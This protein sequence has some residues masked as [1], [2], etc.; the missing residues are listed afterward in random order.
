MVER[1]EMD[2]LMPVVYDELQRIAGGVLGQGGPSSVVATDLVH[3][4]Y[5][6]LAQSDAARWG[7]RSHFLSLAA[8]CMRQVIIDYRRQRGAAKR[9]GDWQRVTLSGVS[10]FRPGAELDSFVIAE[11][12]EQ[13]MELDPRQARVVELR[14]YAGLTNAEIAEVL[15]VSVPTVER[16]W[17]HARAWLS[18]ELEGGA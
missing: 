2:D 14:F 13:L 11:L 1:G 5:L 7:T 10:D 8:R 15:D 9:G 12:V 17:R 18:R 16:E 6:R 4:V 3:E